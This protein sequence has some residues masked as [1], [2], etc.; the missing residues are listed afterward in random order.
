MATDWKHYFSI[1]LSGLFGTVGTRG[2]DRL[3]Y[4]GGLQRKI[5]KF[6][7]QLEINQKKYDTYI[8]EELAE[9]E[10]MRKLI[11][12]EDTSDEFKREFIK[13]VEEF[14][15]TKI[16]LDSQ[17]ETATKLINEELAILRE[18]LS[19]VK[20]SQGVI[21]DLKNNKELYDMMI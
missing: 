6:E 19:K 1:K 11:H 4:A 20:L 13:K 5:F 3:Y 14:K 21:N 16:D 15:E 12:N 2:K 17:M 7:E 18:K 8:N 9:I 10:E